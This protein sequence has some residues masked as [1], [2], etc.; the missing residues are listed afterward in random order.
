[1]ATPP[2]PVDDSTVTS[3]IFPG[4]VSAALKRLKRGKAAGPD[5][6]IKQFKKG[7]KKMHSRLILLYCPPNCLSVMCYSRRSVMRRE[8]T[9]ASALPLDHRP[10]ALLNSD[11]Y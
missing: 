9:A 1:M 11:Y 2:D 4:D 3:A 10:I 7:L 8:K 5:I 6:N